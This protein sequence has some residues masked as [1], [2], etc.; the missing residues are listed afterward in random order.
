MAW[1]AFLLSLAGALALYLAAP[2]QSL[3]ARAWPA[4]LRW[5]GVG[6]LLISLAMWLEAWRPLAAVF[7]FCTLLM[8]LFTVLPCLGAL[9]R[10]LQRHPAGER[11]G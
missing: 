5:A 8:L 10:L 3:L 2:H 6:L 1:A 4:R 7:T 11:H 9:R